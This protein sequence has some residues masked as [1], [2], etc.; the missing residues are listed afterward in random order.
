MERI[1][2]S[3]VWNFVTSSYFLSVTTISHPWLG[4]KAEDGFF[5]I[6]IKLHFFYMIYYQKHTSKSI[7]VWLKCWKS[8]Y[9]AAQFISPHLLFLFISSHLTSQPLSHKS[10][11]EDIGYSI[12]CA[13]LYRF[14]VSIRKSSTSLAPTPSSSFFLSSFVLWFN[15]HCTNAFHSQRCN[16]LYFMHFDCTLMF[17]SFSLDDW[18]VSA[19]YSLPSFLF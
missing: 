11:R 6:L 13:L 7:F 18:I 4:T 19:N 9:W 5:G 1:I 15:A 2:T 16:S 12:Y 17:L 14:I 8:K 10:G 3:H